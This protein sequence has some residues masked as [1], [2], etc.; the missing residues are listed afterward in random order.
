MRHL[1]SE[2]LYRKYMNIDCAVTRRRH[3]AEMQIRVTSSRSAAAPD[4][5]AAMQQDYLLLCL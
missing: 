1:Y 5:L 3:A 2:T 4:R